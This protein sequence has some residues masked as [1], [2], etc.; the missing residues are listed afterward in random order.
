MYR[1]LLHVLSISLSSQLRYI[2]FCDVS[3]P[4]VH[5][6]KQKLMSPTT[7]HSGALNYKK[8]PRAHQKTNESRQE[9][10]FQYRSPVLDCIWEQ[11][12]C[13]YKDCFQ[14]YICFLFYCNTALTLL[15]MTSITG[16]GY[17]FTVGELRSG[18][19]GFATIYATGSQRFLVQ[20]C[21]ENLILTLKP[22]SQ[23]INKQGNNVNK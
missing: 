20:A 21:A 2:E 4:M 9:T 8:S 5:H 14:I 12:M 22:C 6:W 18:V 16:I 23:V 1:C 19:T 3:W 10:G 15:D 7:C 11:G 13:K 17:S